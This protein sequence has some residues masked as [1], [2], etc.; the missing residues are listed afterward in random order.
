[1]VMGLLKKVDEVH[2][3]LPKDYKRGMRV[4]GLI[5]GTQKIIS[6]IERGAI[7]QVANVAMLPGYTSIP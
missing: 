5:I 7:D 3:L 1:M 2:W 6:E 4:P